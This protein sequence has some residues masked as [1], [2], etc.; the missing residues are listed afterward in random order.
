M[1]TAVFSAVYPVLS[2]LLID[3]VR[4]ALFYLGVIYR[5]VQLFL[6]PV[7]LSGVCAVCSLK[8]GI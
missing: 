7:L 1:H 6:Y 8:P 2:V 4:A 5:A 3:K